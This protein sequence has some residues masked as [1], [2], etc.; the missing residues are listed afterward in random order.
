MVLHNLCQPSAVP[1]PPLAHRLQRCG[2]ANRAHHASFEYLIRGGS[3]V[4]AA[5][6]IYQ[7]VVP[8]FLD[9]DG[10]GLGDLD[11]VTARLDYLEWLG[12]NG[13]WLSPCL[14]VAAARARLRR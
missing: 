10:D 8:S 11:G 2:H 6:A 4:V 12:V 14:S 13:I 1:K 9:T 3:R 7:L 5:R